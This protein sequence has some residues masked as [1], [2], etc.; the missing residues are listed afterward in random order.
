MAVTTEAGKRL[1]DELSESPLPGARYARDVVALRVAAIEQEARSTADAEIERLTKAVEAEWYN[2]NMS[3][4]ACE[5]ILPE[6]QA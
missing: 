1:L 5:R 3:A 4:G 2:G 6:R